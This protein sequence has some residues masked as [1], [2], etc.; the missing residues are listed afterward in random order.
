MV[1]A[2]A[3][4]LITTAQVEVGVAPGVE[5][6]ATAQG[7]SGTGTGGVFAGVVD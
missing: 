2:Q 4:A 7:L 1:D 5:F 3:Q 6:G